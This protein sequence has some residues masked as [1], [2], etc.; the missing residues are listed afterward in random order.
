DFSSKLLDCIGSIK[1]ENFVMQVTGHLTTGCRGA[2]CYCKVVEIH[3]ALG[4]AQV[5]TICRHAV[6]SD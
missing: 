1:Y 4:V 5:D 6:I 2:G 3:Q